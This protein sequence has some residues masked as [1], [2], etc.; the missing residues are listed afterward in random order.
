V[1]SEGT[2]SV[3]SMHGAET[4][5]AASVVSVVDAGC[6]PAR[7]ITAG[8]VVWVTARDSD[9]LIA[10]SADLLRTRPSRAILAE[11]PVGSAP[12]GE[13]F[14]RG[15]TR[16][17]V[18][19]TN[20]HS[21]QNASGSLAIVSTARALARDPALLGFVPAD[22]QPRQP[23]VT[24]GGATLLMVNQVSGLLQALPVRDLP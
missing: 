13:Q 19:D 23:A 17:V 15:G 21:K 16:I 2:L 18:A 10:F 6:S 5:P 22:G 7:V 14:V 4:S 9:T 3:V 12:I 1:Q 11:V 20:L 8:Q 24:D